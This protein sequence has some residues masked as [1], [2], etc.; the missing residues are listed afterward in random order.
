MALAREVAVLYPEIREPYR[1]VFLEILKGIR[2]AGV[3]TV[4]YA[5]PKDA[6]AAQASEWLNRTGADVVIVLG[7]RGL[8]I[9]QGLPG[10]RKIV[11]GAVLANPTEALHGFSGIV[12]TPDPAVLF[13]RLK[14][15][16][17]RVRHVVTVYSK[18]QSQWLIDLARQEARRAGISLDAYP[19]ETLQE[20]AQRF[21]EILR[22]PISERDSIWLPQ[23]GRTV[24]EQAVLPFILQEAWNRNVVVF[25]SNPAHV[26]RG[27]LFSLFPDNEALGRSLA[28]QALRRIDGREKDPVRVTPL[29]DLLTAVNVRTAEHLG[30]DFSAR[31]LRRFDLIFPSP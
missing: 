9:A 5:L 28:A 11:V 21:R 7:N 12:L 14:E 17:P 22:G 19:A 4:A 3:N 18:Q 16:A 31:E 29:Q 30:L 10:E 24:D 25:S 1:A 2:D 6:S 13:K 27:A 8:R 26:R 20:A 15:I 23:D